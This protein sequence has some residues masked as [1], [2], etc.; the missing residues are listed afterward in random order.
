MLWPFEGRVGIFEYISMFLESFLNCGILD[1]NILLKKIFL[2]SYSCVVRY[3]IHLFLTFLVQP[4][5]FAT[6]HDI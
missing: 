6:L 4:L 1:H 3:S 5:L 2:S